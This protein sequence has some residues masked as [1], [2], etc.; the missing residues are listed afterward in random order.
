MILRG[1]NSRGAITP[2]GH[3]RRAK[4]RAPSIFICEA[5]QNDGLSI[6]GQ[7]FFRQGLYS[8]DRMKFKG[9]R[10]FFMENVLFPRVFPR[11]SA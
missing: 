7:T 4:N 8:H 1:A 6:G 3:L 5:L 10:V 9:F 11:K 2:L